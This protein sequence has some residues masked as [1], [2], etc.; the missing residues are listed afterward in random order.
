[1]PLILGVR[2]VLVRE[3]RDTRIRGIQNTSLILIIELRESLTPHVQPR[4]D[5]EQFCSNLISETYVD[6]PIRGIYRP[7][8]SMALR[9]LVAPSEGLTVCLRNFVA[10]SAGTTNTSMGVVR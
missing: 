6:H 10:T 9:A 8:S 2:N 3:I 1:M 7:C 5:A 4:G